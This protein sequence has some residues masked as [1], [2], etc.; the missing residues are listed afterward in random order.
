MS[1]LTLP[2]T[3]G[4]AIIDAWVGVETALAD[5]LQREG[6]PV[7]EPIAIK[8]CLDT[9]AEGELIDYA[10]VERLGLKCAGYTRIYSTG[11]GFKI[12]G[13]YG[14]SVKIKMLKGRNLLFDPVRAVAVI[15]VKKQL[16]FDALI[17]RD[18]LT[19]LD[20]HFIGPEGKFTLELPERE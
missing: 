7:P 4:E 19:Q 5:A 1:K 20:F 14:I 16:G 2:L 10:L 18:I 15:G 17:G 9:G 13:L 6:K 12:A 11:D 3:N 8:G